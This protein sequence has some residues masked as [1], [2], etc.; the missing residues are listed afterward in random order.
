MRL[1]SANKVAVDTIHCCPGCQPISENFGSLPRVHDGLKHSRCIEEM[2][3]E[4]A[5]ASK[6]RKKKTKMSRFF[7]SKNADKRER[8]AKEFNNGDIDMQELEN[9]MLGEKIY[10]DDL[11]PMIEKEALMKDPMYLYKKSINEGKFM[12]VDIDVYNTI[13]SRAYPSGNDINVSDWGAWDYYRPWIDTVTPESKYA[14]TIRIR[15]PF[16]CTTDNMRKFKYFG[17]D[18][19][20]GYG[21]VGNGYFIGQDRSITIDGYWNGCYG[22]LDNYSAGQYVDMYINWAG[23][24]NNPIYNRDKS[25]MQVTY[26]GMGGN[27]TIYQLHNLMREGTRKFY[28]AWVRTRYFSEGTEANQNTNNGFIYAGYDNFAYPGR[29]GHT[30]N[31]G[32]LVI[33]PMPMAMTGYTH[34]QATFESTDLTN[35]KWVQQNMMLV[36]TN[37]DPYARVYRAP[38]SG[39]ISQTGA[40]M[41]EFRN[42][43]YNAAFYVDIY[44]D[45]T[46][47][48]TTSIVPSEVPN[49]MLIKDSWHYAQ[50]WND[51]HARAGATIYQRCSLRYYYTSELGNDNAVWGVDFAFGAPISMGWARRQFERGLYSHYELTNNRLP[52]ISPSYGDDVGVRYNNIAYPWV[53]L[54]CKSNASDS[55]NDTLKFNWK[56]RL[57]TH[58]TNNQFWLNDVHLSSNRDTNVTPVW[59]MDQ[60]HAKLK[61]SGISNPDTHHK[62]I[63]IE[64]S[65]HDQYE[66]VGKLKSS[67]WINSGAS[68]IGRNC[69][70][71][72]Y[73]LRA[74]DEN[75]VNS[76]SYTTIVGYKCQVSNVVKPAIYYT[77]RPDGSCNR[78]GYKHY[79]AF[80]LVDDRAIAGNA[81]YRQKNIIANAFG[82][83]WQERWNNFSTAYNLSVNINITDYMH[84][85]GP[86]TDRKSL[87]RGKFIKSC[88]GVIT[89]GRW[90]YVQDWNQTGNRTNTVHPSNQFDNPAMHSTIYYL[91]IYPDCTIALETPTFTTT[92]MTLN[93]RCYAAD[94]NYDAGAVFKV[95]RIWYVITVDGVSGKSYTKEVIANA[96]ALDYHN[97]TVNG[98]ITEAVTAICG[99]AVAGIGKVVRYTMH[100]NNNFDY[101]DTSDGTR[102]GNRNGS[103]TEYVKTINFDL[104]SD[105][106]VTTTAAMGETATVNLILKNSNYKKNVIYKTVWVK[107]VKDTEWKVLGTNYKLVNGATVQVTFNPTS[108]GYSEASY[109]GEQFQFKI[110]VANEV[111]NGYKVNF[112]PNAR[113]KWNSIPTLQITSLSVPAGDAGF[114]SSLDYAGNC[115]NKFSVAGTVSD[116]DTVKVHHY[117]NDGTNKLIV[118]DVAAPAPVNYNKTWTAEQLNSAVSGLYPIDL[119]KKLKYGAQANDSYNKYSVGQNHATQ[120]KLL[121]PIKKSG[122]NHVGVTG[123]S[124]KE[125]SVVYGTRVTISCNVQHWASS[126]FTGSEWKYRHF[127]YAVNTKSGSPTFY[128]QHTVHDGMNIPSSLSFTIDM[129]T[130]SNFI[131][132]EK[133]K[134]RI[135]TRVTKFDSSGKDL[136]DSTVNLDTRIYQSADDYFGETQFGSKPIAPTIV[137]PVANSTSQCGNPSVVFT[138]P[139]QTDPSNNKISAIGIVRDGGISWNDVVGDFGLTQDGVVGKTLSWVVQSEMGAGVH[140]IGIKIRSALTGQESDVKTISYTVTNKNLVVT[141]G[142]LMTSMNAIKTEIDNFRRA[143]GLSNGSY[144]SQSA[145]TY[146]TFSNAITTIVNGYNA[147]IDRIN[148]YSG[149]KKRAAK[150]SIANEAITLASATTKM[151]DYLRKIQ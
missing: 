126:K 49:G 19:V 33:Y 25:I 130:N 58:V 64:G 31:N 43:K 40:V 74:V 50:S 71:P 121:T 36:T 99:S 106:T 17:V 34:R 6:A 102:D 98:M 95:K 52:S 105:P 70:Y 113:W 9:K 149:S 91:N 37:H 97:A 77:S 60:V 116:D 117:I 46:V 81:G 143:Y 65:V 82:A 38:A 14:D 47:R 39:P 107:A 138:I 148:S 35:P 72:I 151:H 29:D 61:A 136:S 119:N 32:V 115:S 100:A 12:T 55:N 139:A 30:F 134:F 76:P 28:R 51:P 131:P 53:N 3:H 108:M 135:Y 5:I 118:S 75:K 94:R 44:Y 90:D 4:R 92:S 15:L 146:I 127:V 111:T 89:E 69:E 67:N 122:Y 73:N 84:S 133:Y 93:T 66:N 137:Y 42:L 26:G 129:K 128:V 2:Y 132:G 11:A 10:L 62:A 101:G 88:V 7:S 140:T 109:R 86:T 87:M 141:S 112:I 145:G 78:T 24:A 125:G 96:N 27:L 123:Y 142:E 104:S 144:E 120:F 13:Q 41:T 56:V 147:V 21:N 79:L 18:V 150:L 59:I 80:R 22:Y 110:D 1:R 114:A 85:A 20:I 57:N 8:L 48:L 16:N 63:G 124:T 68:W 103:T 45:Y 23:R 83:N 54:A